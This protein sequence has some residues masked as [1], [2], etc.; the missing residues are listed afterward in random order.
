MPDKKGEKAVR[1]VS[2]WQEW[3]TAYSLSCISL[4]AVG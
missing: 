4:N 3:L 1:E 2:V